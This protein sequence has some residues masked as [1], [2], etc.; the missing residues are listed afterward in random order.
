MLFPLSALQNWPTP[1]YANPE[2]RGPAAT[3]IV[4]VLLGLVT[5]IL[6]V[7]IYTRVRISRGFGLDDVLIIFAYVRVFL[8]R[9]YPLC[10]SHGLTSKQIPTAAFAVLSFVAMWKFGWGTHVWD[11]PIAL[12]KPSLQF[13]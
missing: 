6:I 9:H 5:L 4:S 13:R 8:G 11:V 1:N 12:T 2:R 3:I 10:L 7:R